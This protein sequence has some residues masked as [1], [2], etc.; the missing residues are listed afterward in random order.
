MAANFTMHNIVLPD[1]TQ[2]FPQNPVITETP[3]CQG[4]LATA[5]E[6]VPVD[7]PDDPPTVADLG[8]LEGGHSAMYA[9]AGY[10]VTGIEVRQSNIDTCEYVREQLGL[11]NLRFVRDDVRN[12][13][14]HGEF[15]I[16]HCAGLLYH[17]EN[18]SS[19]LELIGRCTRRVLILRTHY[20]PHDPRATPFGNLGEWVMHEG[21]IGRLFLEFPEGT[22]EEQMQDLK[23]ASWG[24]PVS[25]WL[26]RKQLMQAMH[27]AGFDLVY[28]QH[29]TRGDIANS[30]FDDH[31]SLGVFIGVKSRAQLPRNVEAPPALEAAAAE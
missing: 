27:D 29:D 21:R 8:C 3:A 4:M 17:L 9:R 12:L 18:P 28:E 20:A 1:G 22:T 6:L 10:D 2:T 7:D 16:V 13:A 19:M 30:T 31:Q 24:N 11:P 5:L 14:D 26:E 25:F 23:W 15:D